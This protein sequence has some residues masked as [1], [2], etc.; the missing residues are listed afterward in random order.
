MNLRPYRATDIE[1]LLVLWWESWH[2]SASFQ[3]PKPPS[4]WRARW[5]NILKNHTVAVAEANGTLLGFAALD[6]ERA[7]LSQIFVASNAKRQGVGRVLFAWATSCCPTGVT[8]KTLKENTEARAF[9]KS[10]G[11]IE[12]GQ[13]VN[14]FSGREEIEYAL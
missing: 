9:Y 10:L 4:E 12:K 2:S 3:H 7:I 5:E 8:L 6:I 11:M 13:S 1:P 14:D